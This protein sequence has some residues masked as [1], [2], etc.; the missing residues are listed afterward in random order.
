MFGAS[1]QRS[2]NI[3]SWQRVQ[4]LSLLDGGT[5]N[6]ETVLGID[7]AFIKYTFLATSTEMIKQIVQVHIDGTTHGR[8]NLTHEGKFAPRI[9]L[10]IGLNATLVK[11]LP[12]NGQ[13]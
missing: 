11:A 2:W 8:T 13:R 1:T 5:W 4:K 6:L 7:S 9:N 3:L 10:L 12:G